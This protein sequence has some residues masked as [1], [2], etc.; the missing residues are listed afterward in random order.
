MDATVSNGSTQA[1]APFL[2]QAVSL[3]R[4]RGWQLQGEGKPRSYRI[5]LTQPEYTFTGSSG[6]QLGLNEVNRIEIVTKS[7]GG[8]AKIDARVVNLSLQ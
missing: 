3:D 6:V 2:V 8:D 1:P 4:G 7:N 5:D